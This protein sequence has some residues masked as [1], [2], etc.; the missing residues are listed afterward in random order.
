MGRL[1][2][3]AGYEFDAHHKQGIKMITEFNKIDY[4]FSAT[5]KV[6]KENI[7]AVAQKRNRHA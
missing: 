3:A 1:L 4:K 5:A 6:T 2:S 7:V